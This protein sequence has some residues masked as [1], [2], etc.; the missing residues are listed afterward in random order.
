MFTDQDATRVCTRGVAIASP[1][2]DGENEGPSTGAS[3]IATAN[4]ST[5]GIHRSSTATSGGSLNAVDE[6]GLVAMVW[7]S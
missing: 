7:T 6:A 4:A 2:P 1:C 3:A 5:S